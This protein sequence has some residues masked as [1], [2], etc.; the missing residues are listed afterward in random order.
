MAPDRF[1]LN[2]SPFSFKITC[3]HGSTLENL[4]RLYGSRLQKDDGQIED[5]SVSLR[6]ASGLR[7][8]LE[9]Q[10]KFCSDTIE[11]FKP[12]PANQ[13]FAAL[14][15]GMNWVVA[16][17]E[18]QHAIM[19]SAVLAKG[20][21][22]VIFP[23]PPGSGKSTLTTYLA[24]SG[25]RLLSDEMALFTPNTTVVSPFVRPICLKNA[26]IDLAKSWFSSG[27]FS[28][29]AKETIKGDVCHLS[30]PNESWEQASKKAK[31]KAIVF[32]R[33]KKHSELEIY[34][35]N[36]QQ[37]FS[38]LAENAFNF[39][40]T[41]TQGFNACVHLVEQCELYAVTYDNVEDLR[42]FLEQEVIG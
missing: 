13:G 36:Q 20:E 32:P 21:E 42:L 41:G 22:A 26:S 24:F 39:G 29:I 7:R 2:L 16:M 28:S 33:Y 40:L 27:A 38:S 5:Y 8:Y 12:V 31:V 4:H 37:G 30:P 10:V 23:A 14:E 25:W 3:N 15:W 17:N 1:F 9:P 34:Q 11:P 6:K 35:L 18:M 19:H